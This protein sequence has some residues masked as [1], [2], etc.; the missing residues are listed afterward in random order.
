MTCNN[1]VSCQSSPPP[2]EEGHTAENWS[3]STDCVVVIYSYTYI[4]TYIYIYIY[5]CLPTTWHAAVVVRC[6]LLIIQ[7]IIMLVYL[8]EGSAQIILLR[9]VE[10]IDQLFYLT[11]SQY[12]DTAPTSPS[13][14][15]IIIIASKGTIRDCYPHCAANCLQHVRSSGQGAFVCKSLATH[16]AL[17]TCNM[18]CHL[19]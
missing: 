9:S 1:Y 4:H 6:W 3:C 15:P 14:D 17:I 18:S 12:I 11:Q 16:R 13:A 8:D 7:V 19:P 5:N 10:A 2:P